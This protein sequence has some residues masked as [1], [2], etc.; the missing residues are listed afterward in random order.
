MPISDSLLQDNAYIHM[1]E[2]VDKLTVNRVLS[3]LK[4]IIDNKSINTTVATSAVV[5]AT[6][7]TYGIAKKNAG[8]F[9]YKKPEDKTTADVYDNSML[10]IDTYRDYINKLHVETSGSEYFNDSVRTKTVNN[11]D[12]KYGY[13]R[14]A[15]VWCGWIRETHN[16]FDSIVLPNGINLYT[17]SYDIG[18]SDL[19][20]MMSLENRDDIKKSVLIP[21]MVD[22]F[23]D[24]V[25]LTDGDIFTINT[26]ADELSSTQ[27]EVEDAKRTTVYE[28]LTA[29]SGLNNQH[30][31][32][33]YSIKPLV[34]IKHNDCNYTKYSSYYQ[35]YVEVVFSFSIS[36][37]ELISMD[38][39]KSSYAIDRFTCYNPTVQEARQDEQHK[40]PPRLLTLFKQKPIV[41][42]QVSMYTNTSKP[43]ALVGATLGLEDSFSQSNTITTKELTTITTNDVDISPI[44]STIILKDYRNRYDSS[45]NIIDNIL[46]FDV[47][48][49]FMA[50]GVYDSTLLGSLL[51][52]NALAKVQIA[53][54]G[55]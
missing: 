49:K 1:N 6:E 22:G 3:K 39:E 42:P 26:L 4:T 54:I 21:T 31:G 20:R 43:A 38:S 18:F 5:G 32:I 48:M 24:V 9:L 45:G 16:T 46:S 7:Y 34:Q 12:V 13:T 29:L 15:D 52:T 17:I 41:M 19:A 28:T 47:N 33:S 53:L 40:V 14:E 35:S 25:T 44:T 37:S 27:G 36:L 10:S 23:E 8:D 30:I 2:T 51:Y 11:E 55:I 50:G